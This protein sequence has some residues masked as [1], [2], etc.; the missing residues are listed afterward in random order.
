MWLSLSSMAYI[1]P[2]NVILITKN[3]IVGRL[4]LQP[5]VVQSLGLKWR[6]FSVLQ[7]VRK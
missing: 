1:K 4:R 5:L 6:F 7:F 2:A 3:K